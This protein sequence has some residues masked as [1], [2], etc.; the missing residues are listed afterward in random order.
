[1][2]I[3]ATNSKALNLAAALLL[4]LMAVATAGAAEPTAES[5]MQAVYDRPQP[6]DTSGLLTMTLIDAKGRERVRSLEQRLATFGG[7]DKKI[8]EFKSPADVK[9]TAFMNW[10]YAE[11]GRSDDQWIYLPALKRVKRISSD[12]KG[13]AFM[14]SD[15]SY[16]DLAERHPS[17]DTHA[18]IGSEIMN[19]EAC[20]I[21]ESKAK[22]ATEGYSKTISW[23]SKERLTGF[24]RE[25]YDRKG[26]L[27]KTLSVQ[28]TRIIGGYLMITRT[29]MHNV[30]K[31][32][33]TR[34]EFAD[35]K[36]DTGITDELFSERTLTRGL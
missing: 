11:A 27:L 10:S 2:N 32:T 28:E 18:I 20:W 9:G 3:K 21:I 30:Q 5:I 35:L 7:V 23:I 19:G 12:G 29:E 15:F 22:D 13:D 34:M 25:Y 4:G 16:D 36:L 24:K 14:G 26:A 8:M 31:N 33:R 1:M 6:A 17:R